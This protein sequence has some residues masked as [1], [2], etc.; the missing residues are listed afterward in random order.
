[1]THTPFTLE[2]LY[3]K[4]EGK[5]EHNLSSACM[6]ALSLNDLLGLYSENER[7]VFNREVFETKLDYS[8]QFGLEK[9]REALVN[10]L[11]PS[12]TV[13]DFLL[14]TGASEA[15]FL[16]LSSLFEAG[17]SIIVQKPIYQSL[18]QVA[19]DRGIKILDWDLDL[20]GM[21]WDLGKLND[22]VKKNPEAKALVINNPNNP[23]GTVFS[24]NEL[25]ELSRILDG[26]Y[27]ISDEVFNPISLHP[28]KAV[29]EIY[30][31]GISISDLSKSFNMPGLR[32]GWIAVSSR[33]VIAR[34]TSPTTVIATQNEVKGKQSP[35]DILETLS[36][37]KNYLSL[38]NNTL[39][40]LIAPWLLNKTQEITSCNKKIIRANL[41]SLYSL[42]PDEVFF[43]LSQK[44]ESIS[45]LCF[46]PKL[47][48]ELELDYF[49]EKNCFLALGKNFGERY[50][51]FCRIGLGDLKIIH[52][53][54]LILC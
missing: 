29:A 18:Y 19:E 21:N 53:Q 34:T 7:E 44:R 13:N 38:R 52:S 15:I 45:N 47:K 5:Y 51:G 40:E 36:S 46:F 31:H 37:H 3:N 27:L 50:R 9:T 12:L 49:L 1:M 16:V 2:E 35:S 11:Y 8:E 42:N 24:E 23:V 41:D 26:R 17:D 25:L 4:Y 48:K 39:S 22:L 43:D 33:A 32:L 10:N 28:T 20:E 6:P 14:T 54:T 30:E